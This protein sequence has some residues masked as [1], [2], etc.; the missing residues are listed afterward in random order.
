MF[1]WRLG[2]L[3][4]AG[5]PLKLAEQ[6]AFDTTVDLHRALRLLEQGC[7]PELAALILL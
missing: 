5:Y 1:D 3:L 2:E 4:R 6:L 7:S